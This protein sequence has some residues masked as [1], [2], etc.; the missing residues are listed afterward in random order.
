MRRRTS[1]MDPKLT[2]GVNFS[3]I[4]LNFIIFRG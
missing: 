3:H 2:P 4:F 1:E